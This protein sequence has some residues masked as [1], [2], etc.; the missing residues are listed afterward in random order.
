M[1]SNNV[2]VLASMARLIYNDFGSSK[3]RCSTYSTSLSVASPAPLH[4]TATVVASK[5]VT[6]VFR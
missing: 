1:N 6:I 4:T 2:F 5:L 3:N